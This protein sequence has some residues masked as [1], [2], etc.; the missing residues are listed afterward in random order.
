MNEHTIKINRVD[1][2]NS[3]PMATQL[4]VLEEQKLALEN[5]IHN[6]SVGLRDHTAERDSLIDRVKF[7]EGQLDAQC[8]LAKNNTEL[9]KQ[10]AHYVNKYNSVVSKLKVLADDSS[11]T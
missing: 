7:L 11:Y 4:R 5:T 6:Q 10:L 9:K 3:C 8:S 1:L 2:M